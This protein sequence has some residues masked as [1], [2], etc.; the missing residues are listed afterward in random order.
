[1]RGMWEGLDLKHESHRIKKCKYC[2]AEIVW[3]KSRKTGKPYPVN[4]FGICDVLRNDFHKCN[5]KGDK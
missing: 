5:K 1:M 2:G 4:F 3:L